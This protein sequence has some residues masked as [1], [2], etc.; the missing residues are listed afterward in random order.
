MVYDGQGGGAY[1]A[2][3]HSFKETLPEEVLAMVKER[4]QQ[5]Q[6]GEFTVPVNEAVSS[7]D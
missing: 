5:I 6:N 7:L 4:E 1:L 2:P 3:F